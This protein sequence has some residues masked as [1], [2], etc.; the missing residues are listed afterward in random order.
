M[1]DYVLDTNIC[2][3]I[4][5]HKPSDVYEKFKT[6]ENSKIAI[7]VITYGEL[8]YGINKSAYFKKSK[9]NLD[10]FTSVAKV[11]PM[12]EKVAYYYGEIRCDLSKKGQII[13][14]NDLWIAAHA[15]SINA[16]LISNNLKE[17]NRVKGLKV[18]NWVK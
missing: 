12:N 8:L 17:F 3:Y 5:N 1:I 7:S 6:L 10:I 13:G 16:V 18:E 9:L 14:N 15:K 2:I 11:L 4:I